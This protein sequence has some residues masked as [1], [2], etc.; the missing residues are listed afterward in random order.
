MDWHLTST[1]V[2]DKVIPDD[3]SVHWVFTYGANHPFLKEDGNKETFCCFLPILKL[4][5]ELLCNSQ[6]ADISGYN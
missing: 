3:E 1:L 6:P 5:E 4:Y 2:W